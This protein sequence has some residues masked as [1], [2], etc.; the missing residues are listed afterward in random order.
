M[1]IA[2]RLRQHI[3]QGNWLPGTELQDG[4]IAL[5]WGVSRPHVREAMKLLCHEGLLSALPRGGM[6]VTVPTAAQIHEAHALQNL[7]T[8]YLADHPAVEQGLAQR[9][10]T[11]VQQRLELTRYSAFAPK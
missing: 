11:M 10:L 3:L 4:D 5:Q 6:K 7:L 8:H 2:E 1:A 9:M